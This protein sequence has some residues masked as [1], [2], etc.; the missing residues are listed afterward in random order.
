M[1]LSQLFGTLAACLSV[2][3]S[4]APAEDA[5]Q[6]QLKDLT[7][8]SEDYVYQVS[9]ADLSPFS[10][11][12]RDYFTLLMITS[13]SEAH[14]CQTCVNWKPILRKVAKAWYSDYLDTNYLLIAEIDL[15]DQTNMALLDPMKI[16]TVPQ[17]WLIPPTNLANEYRPDDHVE[18]DETSWTVMDLV[19]EPHSL[20]ELP[21]VPFEE[22]AFLFAD[23]LAGAVQKPIYL[24]Q[25]NAPS[26]FLV[27][28]ALTFLT[29]M[30]FKKKGPSFITEFVTKSKVYQIFY[31]L[32]LYLLLGGIMFSFITPVPFLAKN[33]QGNLIYISGGNSYQFGVEMVIVGLT[34]FVLGTLLV[35]LCYI[36]QYKVTKNSEISSE[37][38][39]NFLVLVVCG[40]LYFASSVLSS[41]CL[42]KDHEYP[43]YYTKL[44]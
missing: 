35:F 10:K 7:T 4:E 13:T 33:D 11:Y 43:Y 44:F 38:L 19:S 31:F 3:V 24:R 41:I 28:F 42:R 36:G 8:S 15:V 22:Q 39:K 26:K 30:L 12:N 16:S 20:Y 23:W 2:V 34:Y 40:L 29:I 27:T 5:N 17:I 6:V 9:G 1:R 14:G 37:S 18:K 21:Q 32:I 25:E